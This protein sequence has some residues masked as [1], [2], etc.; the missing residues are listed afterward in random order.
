[1]S[2]GSW[3]TRTL[4]A[5]PIGTE[6]KE[7]EMQENADTA[8]HFYVA[9]APWSEADDPE[10]WCI[11][12]DHGSNEI[13]NGEPVSVAS[14]RTEADANSGLDAFHRA[15]VLWSEAIDRDQTLADL[16]MSEGPDD[17]LVYESAEVVA[18]LVALEE[19]WNPP[20]DEVSHSDGTK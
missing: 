15:D 5:R 11:Y 19:V 2:L 16:V 8:A 3:A 9:H 1:M 12:W 13:N 4:F 7:A 6:R 17:P 14:F 10:V 20:L 18:A